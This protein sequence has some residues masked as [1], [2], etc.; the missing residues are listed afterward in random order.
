MNNPARSSLPEDA[1]ESISVLAAP[2]PRTARDWVHTATSVNALEGESREILPPPGTESPDDL[3]ASAFPRFVRNRG[4]DLS[5]VVGRFV[6]GV[7]ESLERG[8]SVRWDQYVSVQGRY[9]VERLDGEGRPVVWAEFY[10]PD[11]EAY[12][13]PH[14]IH[15]RAVASGRTV[16]SDDVLSPER[17]LLGPARMLLTLNG[18]GTE[19]VSFQPW[20]SRACV[21][22]AESHFIA[23]VR[24]AAGDSASTFGV[25]VDECVVRF[26]RERGMVAAP[27][28]EDDLATALAARGVGSVESTSATTAGERGFNICFSPG[29]HW[30]GSASERLPRIS[31]VVTLRHDDT[32][33]LVLSKVIVKPE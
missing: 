19:V 22:E 18:E 13:I 31:C 28:W 8:L 14:L 16:F 7:K 32:W 30:L 12:L 23:H 25:M 3:I 5:M 29:E 6:E 9:G 20:I 17:F 21:E 26:L 10:A 15:A 27:E 1:F 24:Q 11:L 2:D 33:G 4:S